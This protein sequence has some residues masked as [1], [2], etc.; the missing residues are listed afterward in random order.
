MISLLTCF[1]LIVIQS[2]GRNIRVFYQMEAI[3]TFVKNAAVK[4][5]QRKMYEGIYSKRTKN[6]ERKRVG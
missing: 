6:D 2:Q 3:Y 4:T 5:L 1:V